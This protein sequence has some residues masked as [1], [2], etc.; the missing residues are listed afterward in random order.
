MCHEFLN[1]RKFETRS[2]IHN[3]PV[4]VFQDKHKAI[5]YLFER[6][7]FLLELLFEYIL[8]NNFEV[9]F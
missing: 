3:I 4:F 1:A 2:L 9:L 8:V 5:N 6:V 7:V